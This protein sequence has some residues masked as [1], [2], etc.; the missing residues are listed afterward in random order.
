MMLPNPTEVSSTTAE[1][2]LFSENDK[3]LATLLVG[4]CHPVTT[5]ESSALSADYVGAIREFCREK[6]AHHD[7][8]TFVFL[9]GASGE[10]RPNVVSKGPSTLKPRDIL[11]SA[12]IG[13]T[14]GKFDSNS[15]EGWLV[16]RCNEFQDAV[17]QAV[18]CA[19]TNFSIARVVFP[20]E[21]FFEYPGPQKR[22]VSVHAVRLGALT[23]LGISAEP[24]W[25][26]ARALDD[27]NFSGARLSVV[28][29]IDDTWGYL[30]SRNQCKLGG[31]EV[32][33]YLK[34]F[35][36][37]KNRTSSNTSTKIEAACR[38]LLSEL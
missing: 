3:I 34:F 1:V 9:Q 12:L 18:P 38:A 23:L 14:F 4:A 33:G 29:C 8:M 21:E 24:T 2:L 5:M 36:L 19:D 20:L 37:A 31:Y 13:Q 22:F 11:F 7:S 35:S 6:I 15:L 32:G 30:A 17:A 16:R 25:E 26:F 10:V 27:H 28:G